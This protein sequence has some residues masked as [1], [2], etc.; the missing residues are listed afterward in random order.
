[1]SAQGKCFTEIY[2]SLGGLTENVPFTNHKNIYFIV[3][4]VACTIVHVNS[5]QDQSVI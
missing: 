1:M 5:E 3:Q 4:M 2:K